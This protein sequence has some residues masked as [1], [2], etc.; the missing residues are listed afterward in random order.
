MKI[1]VVE[2]QRGYPNHSIIESEKSDDMY[3]DAITG[4]TKTDG[5]CFHSKESKT[6]NVRLKTMTS[7][8]GRSQMVIASVQA[9]IEKVLGL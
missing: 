2:A 7:W 8:S 5:R 6:K 4:A 1:A 3:T 9:L